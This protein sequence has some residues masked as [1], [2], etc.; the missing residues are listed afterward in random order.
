VRGITRAFERDRCAR[1][2]G[3]PCLETG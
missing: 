2:V 1:E 3:Q